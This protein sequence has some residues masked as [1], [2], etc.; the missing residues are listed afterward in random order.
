MS[1]ELI[2]KVPAPVFHRAQR[3]AEVMAARWYATNRGR[4]PAAW[5]EDDARAA[6]RMGTYVAATR[7]D[8]SRGLKF[9]TMVGKY[10]IGYVQAQARSAAGVHGV[11]R[12]S[13][14][15]TTDMLPAE[16]DRPAAAGSN[17]RAVDL[18][19]DPRPRPD[20]CVERVDWWRLVE[21]LEPRQ[22]QVIRWRFVEG[23]TLQE[24]AEQWGCTRER[25]R[26]VQAQAVR[27]LRLMLEAQEPLPEPSSSSAARPPAPRPGAYVAPPLPTARPSWFPPRA[28]WV[29]TKAVAAAL[30]AVGG[31]LRYGLPTAVKE[32][33]GRMVGLTAGT[34]GGHAA[35]IRKARGVTLISSRPQREGKR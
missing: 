18:L 33:V 16:L 6:A 21:R 19:V 23:W 7:F 32:R 3:M 12:S 1:S 27:D 13:G 30:D 11:A 4:C 9:N 5:D 10:A 25:V 20:A 28:C 35:R 24:V 31:D 22:A 17:L 15:W 8:P 14:R 26:Q 34:V 29:T 2:G